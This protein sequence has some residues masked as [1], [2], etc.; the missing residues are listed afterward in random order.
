MDRIYSGAVKCV[1]THAL[2]ILVM[3]ANSAAGAQVSDI[4]QQIVADRRALQSGRLLLYFRRNLDRTHGTI[5]VDFDGENVR[6]ILATESIPVDEAER[7]SGVLSDG[8]KEVRKTIVT[9]DRLLTHDVPATPVGRPAANDF[10]RA[11]HPF[12]P[13]DIALRSFLDPRVIG[14]LPAGL[15]IWHHF[16]VESFL[17]RADRKDFAERHEEYNGVAA[18]RH[19][20]SLVPEGLRVR[21][22]IA[23]LPRPHLIKLEAEFDDEQQNTC[24]D[25][26]EIANSPLSNAGLSDGFIFPKTLEYSRSYKGTKIADESIIVLDASFNTHIAPAIFTL[27]GLDLPPGTL[28]VEHPSRP[29]SARWNGTELVRSKTPAYVTPTSIQHTDAHRGRRW[30]LIANCALLA[31]VFAWMA[32]M[33][34]RRRAQGR[35]LS[36]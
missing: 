5:G 27:A 14:L 21:L 22:W 10:D 9:S 12:G 17:A 8:R 16:S 6:V 24:L 30:L 19:E 33:S 1:C 20:F 36:S 26:V 31:I 34:R 35:R 15:G 3:F 28:V 7:P 11:K 23:E 2:S 4:E 32:V 29:I 13:D 25:R 18:L